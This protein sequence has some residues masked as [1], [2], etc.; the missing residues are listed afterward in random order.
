[1][2]LPSVFWDSGSED[3]ARGY[4]ALDG[5]LM[6]LVCCK[7][8]ALEDSEAA[9]SHVQS[10]HGDMFELLLGLERDES[11]LSENQVEILRRIRQGRSDSEIVS[12]GLA[13][14]TSTVRGY[15]SL[16]R[17]KERKAKV[18]LAISEMLGQG[19]YKKRRP[20]RKPSKGWSILDERFDITEEEKKRVL[21]TYFDDDKGALRSFP[22][23]E[24]NK[25]VILEK[26]AELF[27]KG[28]T[29]DEKEVN[30]ILFRA[31]NDISTLRRY[32]VEY[33]F[34]A[35]VADGT[36]YWRT[37]PWHKE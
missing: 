37:D 14:A 12:E 5:M 10:K 26:L 27:E 3:M 29:Y 25:I 16:L 7:S 20:G 17:E 6:C 19:D 31:Y 11:G 34:L 32:L 8:F 2:K 24:K 36:A 15:R 18:F 28:R 35:R 33:K 1:M 9:K 13:G 30:Q 22:S 21:K 23:K 4:S